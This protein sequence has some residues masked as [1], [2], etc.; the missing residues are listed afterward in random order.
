V[1]TDGGRKSIAAYGYIDDG[2]EIIAAARDYLERSGDVRQLVREADNRAE[3]RARLL[4]RL[5]RDDPLEARKLLGGRR[6]PVPARLVLQQE[7]LR[8]R[9][10][11]DVGEVLGLV[12]GVRDVEIFNLHDFPPIKNSY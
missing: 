11:Q 9:V 4:D 12:I 5:L 3:R 6:E 7:E 10:A 2:G 8:A 1:Q